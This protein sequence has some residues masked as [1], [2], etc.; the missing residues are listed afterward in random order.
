M[1]ASPAGSRR[2]SLF[3][4]LVTVTLLLAIPAARLVNEM[5]ERIANTTSP[6]LT[7]ASALTALFPGSNDEPV[8]TSDEIRNKAVPLLARLASV[9]G[10]PLVVRGVAGRADGTTQRTWSV[11][12]SPV[13][14]GGV[15]RNLA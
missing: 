15:A 4:S 13:P 5:N 6:T 14:S 8:F 3:C 2:V 11:W 10:E 12:Y 9:P 1:D 7:P